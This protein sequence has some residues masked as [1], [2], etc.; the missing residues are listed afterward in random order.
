MSIKINIDFDVVLVRFLNDLTGQEE[1]VTFLFFL[2]LVATA[3]TGKRRSN[4][5]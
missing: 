2:R 5:L 3:L 4:K 1:F